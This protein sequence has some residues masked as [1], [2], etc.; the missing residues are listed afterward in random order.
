MRYGIS[1]ALFP[2]AWEVGHARIRGKDVFALGPLR[3]SI[4]RVKGPLAAYGRG[5]TK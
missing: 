3:F 1:I 2:T 4:H 5:E